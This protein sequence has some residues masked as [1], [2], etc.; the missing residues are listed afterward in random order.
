MI[1]SLPSL[2]PYVPQ[3]SELFVTNFKGIKHLEMKDLSNINL[4]IGKN[5]SGKS[6]IMEALYYTGKEFLGANL[7]QCVTRRANRGQWSARELFYNYDFSLPLEL[8][9]EEIECH[10]HLAALKKLIPTLLNIAIENNLQLFV[11]THDYNIW[12][13]FETEA[14]ENLKRTDLLKTYLVTRNTDTNEVICKPQTKES[15]DE[16]WTSVDTELAGT[17]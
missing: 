10:Q 4:F 7:P 12:R 15:A 16:F 5:N 6:T 14:N 8:F 2:K 1:V 9:I 3:I 17:P 11:T 13:L